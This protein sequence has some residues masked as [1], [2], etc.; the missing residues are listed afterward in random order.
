MRAQTSLVYLY[1]WRESFIKV[2]KNS[3]FLARQK[4]PEPGNFKLKVPPA[5][6]FGLGDTEPPP[7]SNLASQL[8]STNFRPSPGHPS[9][10][11]PSEEKSNVPMKLSRMLG[12]SAPNHR[13]PA[14]NQPPG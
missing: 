13:E 10:L 3:V 7:L 1:L 12:Y 4:G 8:Y 5:F 2:K 14:E 6:R 11:L 9:T